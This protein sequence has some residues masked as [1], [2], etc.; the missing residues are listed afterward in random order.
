MLASSPADS[1]YN[2]RFAYLRW[3]AGL[4]WS[5]RDEAQIDLPRTRRLLDERHCGLRTAKD[6]ILEYLAARKLGG[7]AKGSILCF[8]GP[9]GVGKT[10][11][12]RSIADAMGRKLAAIS[13]G[14]LSDETELRGHN[15]TWSRAQPG[16]IVRELVGIGVKNPVLVL[17]EIDKMPADRTQRRRPGV[18]V[19]R[20]ARPGAERP[21][22]RP[23][24]RR[25]VR[26]VGGVLRRHRQRPGHDPGAAPGSPGG[27]RA[28][29][30]RQKT[31]S[32]GSPCRIWS[33]GS[34]PRTG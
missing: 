33:G 30:L 26:P 3:L 12:A 22:R 4:P 13:C 14:G 24:R 16:R 34:S 25:A 29:G 23:L 9:P 10:S 15:R 17:D 6:R 31:R 18:G 21:V 2:H 27:D 19:A 32:S 28:A 7:G 5:A 20:G 11:L 8:V 1:D